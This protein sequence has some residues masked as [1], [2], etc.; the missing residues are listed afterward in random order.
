M[1]YRVFVLKV[2]ECEETFYYVCSRRGNNLGDGI[3]D[4]LHEKVEG[5]ELSPQL[6]LFPDRLFSRRTSAKKAVRKICNKLRNQG[7]VVNPWE[8]VYSLYVI[9]LKRKEGDRSKKPLVYVGETSIE[10]EQRYAQH[11][12]GGRLASSK[13]TGRAVGLRPDLVPPAKLFN[14]KA[15]VAA[16]THLGKRLIKEGYEVVGPQGL[17]Q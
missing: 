15:S 10:V 9:E 12:S 13:V 3:P 11:L 17:G 6:D 2:S 1:G 14:R 8:P 4:N 7:F 5:C 16:E